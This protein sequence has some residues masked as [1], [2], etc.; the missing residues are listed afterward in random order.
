MVGTLAIRKWSTELLFE[1]KQVYDETVSYTVERQLVLWLSPTKFSGSI[2]D[3]RVGSS[4]A[5]DFFSFY[6]SR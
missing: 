3:V 2:G 6:P 4:S 1:I 5:F